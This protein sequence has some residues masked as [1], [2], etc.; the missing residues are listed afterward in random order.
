MVK[1]SSSLLNSAPLAGEEL[2]AVQLRKVIGPPLFRAL[3]MESS[4]FSWGNI[5]FLVKAVSAL[6]VSLLPIPLFKVFVF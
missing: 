1:A 2:G 3:D 4:Y 5:L 6:R